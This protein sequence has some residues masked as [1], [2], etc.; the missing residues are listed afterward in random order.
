MTG[1]IGKQGRTCTSYLS[2][3]DV[4][5]HRP[6][7]LNTRR[8]L[9]L[10]CGFAQDPPGKLDHAG[11]TLTAHLLPL[12]YSL[13][14]QIYHPSSEQL[15]RPTSFDVTT[16]QTSWHWHSA[17]R[18]L[19]RTHDKSNSEKHHVNQNSRMDSF[20]FLENHVFLCFYRTTIESL[21]GVCVRH[22]VPHLSTL[23]KHDRSNKSW[24]EFPFWTIYHNKT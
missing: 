8:I 17:I 11:S 1:M 20:L 9:F 24:V 5:I 18:L 10:G 4:T 13:G 15:Q 14:G 12:R 16:L 22:S 3:V 19:A 21:N 7:S 6:P 2:C 23:R